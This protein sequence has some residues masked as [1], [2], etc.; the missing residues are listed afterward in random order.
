MQE[1]MVSNC[2]VCVLQAHKRT[3]DVRL[4]TVSSS[5][6]NAYIQAGQVVLLLLQGATSS[7]TASSAALRLNATVTGLGPAFKLSL[8]L[9]NSN[10]EPML[11]AALVSS[12]ASLLIKHV[13]LQMNTLHWRTPMRG[14]I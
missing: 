12:C 7:S 13:A 8:E 10:S 5:G 1:Q 4:Q 2:R 6:I 14:A 11:D 9:C 3:N